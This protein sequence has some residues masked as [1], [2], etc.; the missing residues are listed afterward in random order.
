[1]RQ[2]EPQGYEITCQTPK[3]RKWVHIIIEHEGVC[4]PFLIDAGGLSGLSG[5]LSGLS[6]FSG[7]FVGQLCR[8]AFPNLCDNEDAHISYRVPG[9]P[10]HFVVYGKEDK[11]SIVRRMISES[12]SHGTAIPFTLKRGRPSGMSVSWLKDVGCL[13][14]PIASGQP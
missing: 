2:H 12:K 5:G 11:L 1:M 3:K 14:A 4:V 8:K 10:I 9:V 7:L 13:D 6:G